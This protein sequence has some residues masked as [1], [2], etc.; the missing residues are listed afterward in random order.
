MERKE[1]ELMKTVIIACGAGVAT[2]TIIT[3]GVKSLLD[4]AKIAH[5][6][7]QCSLNEVK[8]HVSGSDLIVS[9]MPLQDNYGIP[10]VVGISFLT[11]VSQ[12]KTKQEILSYLK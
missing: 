3:Y 5:R 6:I 7:I 10:I 4:D 12:E 11:G 8:S 2:S 9:S 1:D